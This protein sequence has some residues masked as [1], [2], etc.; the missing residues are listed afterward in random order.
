MAFLIL[1]SQYNEQ[2]DEV[3]LCSSVSKVLA[4][5]NTF[6]LFAIAYIAM[7]ELEFQ[8]DATAHPCSKYIFR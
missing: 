3:N 1:A 6:Y 5:H 7:N 2:K 4:I 8:L